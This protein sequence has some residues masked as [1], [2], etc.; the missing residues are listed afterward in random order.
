MLEMDEND[1]LRDNVLLEK[2]MLMEDARSRSVK[3]T[4]LTQQYPATDAG[5]RAMY[6]LAMAKV[7]LYKDS[8]NSEEVK[9]KLLLETRQVLSGFIQEHPDSI[10][11]SQAEAMLKS[12]PEVSP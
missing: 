1:G 3:L 10:Y 6:E 9:A 11:A 5:V 8:Q 4:E 7:Q 12:L 2:A